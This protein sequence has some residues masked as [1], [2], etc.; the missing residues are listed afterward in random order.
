MKVI[1]GKGIASSSIAIEVVSV[2][3]F[4]KSLKI[5]N[6]VIF[7][8]G[9]N[10]GLYTEALLKLMPSAIVFAFEPSTSAQKA[11]ENRFDSH[12]NV[13]LIPIALGNENKALN[14]YSDKNGSGL[15]SFTKRRIQHFGIEMNY[16]ESV[17]CRKL[18][19]WTLERGTYPDF[20]KIDVEGHE[21]DVLNGAL[22]VLS[23]VSVVQ[24]EF[25]GCN[26]DTRTFFQDFWYF[27]ATH[28]F[29]MYR[30]TS[31]GVVSILS[32]SEEDEYFLT[33]NYLAVRQLREYSK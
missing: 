11:F 27:F 6:P 5:D 8:V 21:L 33:T 7:D 22:S 23:K 30:I 15:A 31:S 24:F 18:D 17:L 4:L 25:G 19:D 26:I 3:S 20:I 16:V 10:I 2:V 1:Q 9:A 14:L 32:Y 28:G 13:H 12:T 29:S